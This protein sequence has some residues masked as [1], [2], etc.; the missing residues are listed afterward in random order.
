MKYSRELKVSLI[1]ETEEAD[2]YKPTKENQKETKSAKV[3]TKKYEPTDNTPCYLNWKNY[4]KISILLAVIAF[5]V[6]AIVYHKT[7]EKYF[8]DFLNWMKANVAIGAFAFIGLYWYVSMY[9]IV[10]YSN[11]II[12]IKKIKFMIG[13]ALYS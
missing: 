11:H 1:S 13:F 5:L 7:T 8:N 10:I 6:L 3:S 4:I 12:I 2:G 9:S